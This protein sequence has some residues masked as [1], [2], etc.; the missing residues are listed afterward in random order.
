MLDWATVQYTKDYCTR[1]RF[2]YCI[3][4]HMVVLLYSTPYSIQYNS[5]VRDW[6]SLST[7]WLATVQYHGSTVQ[8]VR[9]CTVH[10]TVTVKY[11]RPQLHY[12]VQCNGYQKLNRGLSAFSYITYKR[13]KDLSWFIWS[14]MILIYFCKMQSIKLNAILHQFFARNLL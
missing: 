10:L 12:V 11:C 1:K 3:Y 8:Y 4:S 14:G 2:S 5:A 13:K 9:T 6:K 7:S